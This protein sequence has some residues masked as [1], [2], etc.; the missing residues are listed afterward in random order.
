MKKSEAHLRTILIE[1][2][3]ANLLGLNE[4]HRKKLHKTVARAAKKIAKTFTKLLAK[5][6]KADKVTTPSTVP[7]GLRK[8]PARGVGKHAPKPATRP[9][10]RATASS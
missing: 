1:N 10:A 6:P 7:P 8:A 4:Q 3:Q 9:I 2:L 5:Q